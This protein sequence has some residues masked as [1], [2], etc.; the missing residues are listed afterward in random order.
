MVYVA[1]SW[2]NA[3]QQ[4]VVAQL[5]ASGLEVYDFRNPVS[6]FKWSNIDPDWQNWDVT[7]YR[8]GLE[9]PLAEEG[10][11]NDRDAVASCTCCVLILPCGRSAHLELG[12]AIG[13][14]KPGAI[15]FPHGEMVEPELMYKFAEI[16]ETLDGVFAF[17][18]AAEAEATAGL[19]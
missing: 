18:R 12:W 15:Y 9:H 5:R 10:F 3:H 4:Y 1:S 7:A 19:L 8:A 14:G 6:H 16:Y 17:A 11:R 13:Q 2:R